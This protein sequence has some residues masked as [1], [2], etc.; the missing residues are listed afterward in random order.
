MWENLWLLKEKFFK[1]EFESPIEYQ[2]V[3]MKINKEKLDRVLKLAI[4]E[5]SKPATTQELEDFANWIRATDKSF[6][7]V[8]KISNNFSNDFLD[9]QRN[10]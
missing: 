8:Y 6:S 7:N 4:E 2:G 1:M 3:N 9:K 5:A 10:I